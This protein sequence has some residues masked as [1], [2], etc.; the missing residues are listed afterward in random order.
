MRV[1]TF[2]ITVAYDGTAYAGWQVQPDAATVQGVLERAAERLNGERTPVLGAGRTDAGVHARGQAAR[3]TT[4]RDLAAE[5]VPHALNAFLPEDV[6]VTG[7]VAVEAGFH[8]IRDAVAKHYR[9]SLKSAE[10]DDPFDRRYVL[11]I[12]ERPDLDAMRAAAAHLVG[13]RDFAGFEKS[14]SPREHTVRTLTRLDVVEEGAYI[15]LHFVADGF[16][17]GMARNLAGTLLRAG[18]GAL[19]PD[20]LPDGLATR[21]RT[22]A[23]PCLPAHALCLMRVHYE[24]PN[25]RN[26]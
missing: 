4:T 3:F 17:Y 21:S 24:H 2:R 20:A 18:Q 26:G 6:V 5:R 9:Y 25:R 23:G 13:T 11:R 14:G 15:Q 22:V 16:L 19:A 8:P 7:A 1:R 12:P 10:F